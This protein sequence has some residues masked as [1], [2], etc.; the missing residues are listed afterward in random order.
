V[1]WIYSAEMEDAL[2]SHPAGVRRHPKPVAAPR[3]GTGIAIEVGSREHLAGAERVRLGRS[4]RT[5]DPPPGP[6]R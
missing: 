6:V 1:L 5:D 4:A 3:R 2:G